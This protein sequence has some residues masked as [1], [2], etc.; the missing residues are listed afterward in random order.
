MTLTASEGEDEPAELDH[1][2]GE[3]DMDVSYFE[4]WD[5][6]NIEVHHGPETRDDW[7][8][9]LLKQLKEEFDKVNVAGK[10]SQIFADHGQQSRSV[11]EVEKLLELFKNNCQIHLCTGQSRVE[12][13]KSDGGVLLITWRCCHGH[14]GVW[15]SSKVLCIK[16]EQNVYTTTIMIAVAIII[17][18]GNYEKFS[19]FCKF[20]G[21][22]FISR[23]TL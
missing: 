1:T 21:L 11:V 18:G 15:S 5:R 2:K 8:Q 17:T 4:E 12:N 10:Q 13:W 23:S 16:K 3:E 22:S 6:T 14:G 7:A 9:R 20:L 19:L